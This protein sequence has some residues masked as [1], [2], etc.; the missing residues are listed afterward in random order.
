VLTDCRWFLER[1]RE[2]FAFDA[3]K[4]SVIYMPAPEIS[5]NRA[6]I[7]NASILNVLWAS[8]IDRGKRL[9][10]VY[11]IARIFH[12]APFHFHLYGTPPCDA[13]IQDHLDALANMPNVTLHGEYDGFQS[14]PLNDYQVFLYT[15]ERDGLPNVLL[16]AIATGGLPIVA[17]DVGGIKELV[18][19]ETGFLVSGPEDV[20][21]Y[22]AQLT[23][24]QR[25]YALA[26]ARVAAAQ[27]L[28]M[29]RHS[30]DAFIG[31]LNRLNGYLV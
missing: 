1:L 3:S 16:E 10:L 4:G 2:I 14:L 17:P 7:R 31:S 13:Q 8:R 19:E 25:D 9:D 5:R 22:V 6:S 26:A 28:L 21:G 11:E 27:R 18:N 12:G 30:W 23:K 15:S 24:I 29:S 20:D